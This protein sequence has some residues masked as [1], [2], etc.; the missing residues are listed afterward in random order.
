MRKIWLS[1]LMVLLFVSLATAKEIKIGVLS[2]L[3]GP[4]SAV[5]R[6][7]AKG[8][9]DCVKYLN[10]QGGIAG[11][12][13]KA[14]QVDY[15]YN[16][17]QAISAY[18]RFV[19]KEKI[20]ALQGWGT[21]DTEALTRFVAKDKIPTFSASYSAHLTDPKK[22]PYNFFIAADYSTQIRAALKFFKENW[23]EPR[24]PR[25]AFIYPDHPYGLAPI[26]A[27][28][29]YAQEIGYEIVGEENVSLKAIDATTQL[30]SLKKKNPDYVWIGGTT[31]S[32]AVI[33][34]DAK[35]LNFSPVFFV[36][37]WGSDE[38]ILKLAPG[39]CEGIYSLQAAAIYGQQVPGMKIIESLTQGQ[40]Q[41]THYI[42]G[43]ASMLVM[44][45]GIELA[46]QK[47]QI[48]GPAIKQAL[49]TLRN[50][51]PLGLT[52]PISYFPDDHRPNMSVFIYQIKNGKFN[53][54]KQ[55]DLERK[56]EWLGK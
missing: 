6:P 9:L 48:S 22:A 18:K 29:E 49:E 12:K 19:N 37:I 55:V 39:A 17:Q 26:P 3:S 31:P 5:G 21:Q 16:A 20:V 30:L 44:A 46:A 53:F 54:V 11:Y 51:D 47:G 45:K 8:I 14:I 24:A 52:P 7:Y 23:K 56:K 27:A 40:V 28:K 42:R 32:T 35:K 10:S 15:A 4:T 33:L 2:D 38:N 34:K 25:L 36:N 13:I 41:M 1:F 43:F 50:Y